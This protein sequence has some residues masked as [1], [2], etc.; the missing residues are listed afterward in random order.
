MLSQNFSELIRHVRRK[1]F[2]QASEL[3]LLKIKT[4]KGSQIEL[5]SEV[6]GMK[7]IPD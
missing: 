7:G 2:A 3:E 4:K 6:I 1:I 5:P